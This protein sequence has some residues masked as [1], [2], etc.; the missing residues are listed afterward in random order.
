MKATFIVRDLT[1]AYIDSIKSMEAIEAFHLLDKHAHGDLKRNVSEKLGNGSFRDR[2]DL[3]SI[4][5]RDVVQARFSIA[6]RKGY[7]LFTFTFQ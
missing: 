3:N 1:D 4:L 7:L 5:K 2:V 6:P